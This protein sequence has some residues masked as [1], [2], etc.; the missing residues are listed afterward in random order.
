MNRQASKDIREALEE[1]DLNKWGFVILRCTYASNEKWDKFMSAV[2]EVARKC[3]KFKD[4]R[5]AFVWN[6]IEDR[7][8]LEGASLFDASRI[9]VEWVKVEG[10]KELEGRQVIEEDEDEDEG[11]EE[12]D[13]DNED[14]GE[15]GEEGYYDG[16]DDP[17]PYPRYKFFVYVDEE[18]L[19]NVLEHPD[20]EDM[21]SSRN[22]F[23]LVYAENLVSWED[24][25]KTHIDKGYDPDTYDDE[26]GDFIPENYI[27]VWERFI[28]LSTGITDVP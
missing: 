14:K 4:V 7:D 15:D 24:N 27:M 13:D 18:S 19:D 6:I 1:D 23:N 12:K 10:M 11:G 22:Y 8:L 9:F 28:T 17:T 5:D 26:L 2:R 25:R 20:L 3:I 16:Y 21:E